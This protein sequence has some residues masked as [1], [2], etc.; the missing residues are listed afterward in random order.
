M[1]CNEI[2]ELID[3]TLENITNRM[4]DDN[5]KKEWIYII[6]RLIKIQD[7]LLKK[8]SIKNDEKSI[9]VATMMYENAIKLRA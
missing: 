9:L 2:S 1:A 8:P 7:M 4:Y 3:Y 6:C 5:L